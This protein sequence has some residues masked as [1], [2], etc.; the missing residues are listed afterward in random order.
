MNRGRVI[1]TF[2]PISVIGI[3]WLALAVVSARTIWWSY[4]E[5]AYFTS[6]F[7]W[8]AGEAPYTD[9]FV[10]QPVGVVI[11]GFVSE[12]LGLGIL[13]V[14]AVSF[15]CGLGL[16]GVVG[17]MAGETAKRAEIGDR[18]LIGLAAAALLGVAPELVYVSGEAATVAPAALLTFG[19]YALLLTRM[20]RRFVLAGLILGLATV[21]RIQPAMLTP[22]FA[23]TIL[24]FE[25]WR[26]GL[27]GILGF[28][29]GLALA[30][31]IV[32]GPMLLLVDHYDWCVFGFQASQPR[33]SWDERLAVLKS[34]LSEPPVTLGGVG[35][36]MSLLDRRSVIRAL[37]VSVLLATAIAIVVPGYVHRTYL[38]FVHPLLAVV[39]AIW[40]FEFWNRLRGRI[41]G[42]G[43]AVGV[44]AAIGALQP[45]AFLARVEQRQEQQAEYLNELRRAPGRVWLCVD[46][47]MPLAAGKLPIGGYYSADP[48][49]MFRDLD[50]FQTWVIEG[51]ASADGV[52]VTDM[53]VHWIAPE[54]ARWLLDSGKPLV[55]QTREVRER[56]EAIAGRSNL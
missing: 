1:D 52:A 36:V 5:G 40:G 32:H 35:T 51:T 44:L 45:A 3:V 9:V 26:S 30:A 29:C 37:A 24:L 14:R 4:D 48:S 2:V 10:A 55:F 42:F 46:G 16:L 11:L 6:A 25:G 47:R 31:G 49:A 15:A 22:V 38:V 12:K 39:A 27:F 8:A 20:R 19:G 56:F 13:G 33:Y 23:A 18:R 21:F 28:G 54:T 50:Q 41:D 43:M 7:R 53:M 34:F 17:W